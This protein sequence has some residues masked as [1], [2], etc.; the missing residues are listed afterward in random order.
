MTHLEPEPPAREPFHQ[1]AARIHGDPS[2]NPEVR[3]VY[4]LERIADA[5]EALLAND[6][7]RTFGHV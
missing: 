6:E 3:K 7:R 5:L 2:V 1:A 4:A